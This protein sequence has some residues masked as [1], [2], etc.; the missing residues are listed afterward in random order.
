MYLTDVVGN[1]GCI[2]P[3]YLAVPTLF[4]FCIWQT[5][6][7]TVCLVY[8]SKYNSHSIQMRKANTRSLVLVLRWFLLRRRQFS[9]ILHSSGSGMSP[10]RYFKLM[11]LASTEILL[12]F[13]TSLYIFIS[14][15]SQPLQPWIGWSNLHYGF[16]DVEKYMIQDIGK[17]YAVPMQI[18]RFLGVV[19][20][21]IFLCFFGPTKDV[22]SRLIDLSIESQLKHFH[23]RLFEI[24]V[25]FSLKSSCVK[26]R[27]REVLFSKYDLNNLGVSI[28]D[29]SLCSCDIKQSASGQDT[30]P[31]L[32]TKLSTSSLGDKNTECETP[33]S[34]NGW[35]RG[36]DLEMQDSIPYVQGDTGYNN[37]VHVQVE[38]YT[39]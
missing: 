23:C 24:T 16:S 10:R 7:N 28:S 29:W 27:E 1:Y 12:T 32:L 4:I 26:D 8:A 11:A 38:R 36:E 3:I 9:A 22:S 33:S 14:N 35:K 17:V 25:Q 5:V 6:I 34:I 19:A 18:G 30:V 21:F 20:V 31:Q 15:A 2:A 13:P 39:V 37:R